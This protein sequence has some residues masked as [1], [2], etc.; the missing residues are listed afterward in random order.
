VC[1]A[2]RGSSAINSDFRSEELN[3]SRCRHLMRVKERRQS[4]W[5]VLESGGD[6]GSKSDFRKDKMTFRRRGL[7]FL[8]RLVVANRE[9]GAS[10]L[11][12]ALMSWL[13]NTTGIILA[14]LDGA[15]ELSRKTHTSTKK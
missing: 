5:T 13:H 12:L 2:N 9:V 10:T 11:T 4:A 8:G 6:A 3:C 7:L 1:E 14:L 15:G